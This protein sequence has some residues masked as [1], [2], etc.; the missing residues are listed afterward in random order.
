MQ[1]R[2]EDQP[3]QPQDSQTRRYQAAQQGNPAHFGYADPRY[4]KRARLMSARG[5]VQQCGH[6]HVAAAEKE[7]VVE[8]GGH[9]CQRPPMARPFDGKPALENA[10]DPS[11]E[12]NARDLGEQP[13]Y[14]DD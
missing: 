6:G 14:D 12:E 10:V 7:F 11:G 5:W 9:R 4:S 2:R 1:D 13:R 3:A 8:F